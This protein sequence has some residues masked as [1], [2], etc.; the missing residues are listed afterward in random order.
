M[1][2][3]AQQTDPIAEQAVAAEIERHGRDGIVLRPASLP[4]LSDSSVRSFFGGLPQLPPQLTWP[5]R[6]VNSHYAYFQFVAQIDLSELPP[7]AD[8]PLPKAGTLYFF[9]NLTKEWMEPDDA[10]VLFHP[11][12]GDVLEERAPP[13]IS[14]AQPGE[15]W[16]W[17]APGELTNHPDYKYPIRFVACRSYRDYSLGPQAEQGAPGTLGRVHTQMQLRAFEAVFGPRRTLEDLWTFDVGDD[18]WPFAWCAIEHASRAL[19]HQVTCICDDVPDGDEAFEPVLRAAEEWI[20][21][22]RN[23]DALSRPDAAARADFRTQWRAWREEIVAIAGRLQIPAS[24]HSKYPILAERNER[25]PLA[26]ELL[27]E[28]IRLAC[29]LFRDR[30]GDESLV[31]EKYWRAIDDDYGWHRHTGHWHGQSPPAFN[32]MLGYGEAV[33]NTPLDRIDDVLLLQIKPDMYG[34]WWP[35]SDSFGVIQFWIEREDLARGA[36]DRVTVNFDCT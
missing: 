10:R 20:E 28:A 32:Q 35:D 23:H 4:V 33:Q 3:D 25:R 15:P 12:S 34:P 26:D 31:P 7:V 36:F 5:A 22:A 2:H 9:A 14:V 21:S 18:S 8:S 11:V 19:C 27:R 30:G 16:P 1:S 17:L 29:C 13:S 24:D 6:V